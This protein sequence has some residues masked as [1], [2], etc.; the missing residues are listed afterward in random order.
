MTLRLEAPIRSS[1]RKRGPTAT[2][3]GSWIPACAG[4]N[5]IARRDFV[6]AL[7]GAA[8]AWPLAAR[9]QQ[10]AMPV[11]GFLSSRSAED[12]VRVVAAF[13]QG[14]AETGYVD[15][16]NAAIEFRWAQGQFDRLPAFAVELV[17]R[18][19]TVLAAVGG[20]Q[21]AGAAKAETDT[22]PIV[23]GIGEDPVK[24]GLVSNLNRPGANVTGA[25]FF[26]SL[27]GAKRLGLLRDLTPKAEVFAL[28]VNQNSS[29]GQRQMTD[30]QEAAR[31]LGLRLVV[32]NGSSDED[33]DAAFAGLGE[34][35]V[36][37]LLVGADPFFDPRRDRLVALAAQHR[38]PAIYQFRDY[39]L[40]GGLMSYGASITD[41][42]RQ[43]GVYVGRVLK[44]DK[45]ADL[46]VMLPS[47]F[48]LVINLKTARALSIDISPNML[49]LA[50]E[51][52]E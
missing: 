47:K 15:G 51:V 24:E 25:T 9:A 19:V 38:V 5:G 12:S 48:E 11:I 40:A 6:L 29:Q 39:V 28:L 18:P 49:S 7:A 3:R 22:I 4:M 10:P 32:L 41:L 20:F 34:Q 50:D 36:S 16:R 8:A 35:K 45:P 27:L 46:P 2:E 52:I 44:G 37:A 13:R 1:P 42:Y 14:L 17:R 30:V 43:V 23:F 33:I 26:T 31:A 21:A